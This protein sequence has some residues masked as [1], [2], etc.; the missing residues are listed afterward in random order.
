M[1]VKHSWLHTVTMRCDLV[2]TIKW[3]ENAFQHNDLLALSWPH[4]FLD[5]KWLQMILY[6]INH[7]LLP[8]PFGTEKNYFS[9]QLC[10]LHVFQLSR[11]LHA[12]PPC[13]RRV[14]IVLAN[15]LLNV[16]DVICCSSSRKISSW[17][18]WLNIG[19][20]AIRRPETVEIRCVSIWMH[21]VAVTW[22]VTLL[23][24]T[25]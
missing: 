18:S 23:S 25:S 16:R 12:S 5:I 17:Y 1:K 14:T 6:L 19:S 15:S 21:E 10:L 7:N 13:F 22:L 4:V 8:V 2:I 11:W 3:W 20:L 24:A 9:A